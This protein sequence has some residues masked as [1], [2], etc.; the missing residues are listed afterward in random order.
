MKTCLFNHCRRM[1]VGAFSSGPIAALALLTVLALPS[2]A[3]EFPTK[4]IRIV[5]PS[6]PGIGTDLIARLIAQRLNERLGWT[7]LVD[8]KPGGNYLIGS[9]TVLQQPADGHTVL[10]AVSSMTVLPATV[11]DLPVNML[12]DFAAVTRVATLPTVVLVTPALPAKTMPELVAYAKKNPTALSYAV[13]GSGSFHHLA[14]EL[15]KQNLLISMTH[16]PYKDTTLIADVASG[17]V[18]VAV[19]SVASVAQQIRAGTLRGLAILGPNRSPA[20]PDVPTM[21]ELGLPEIDGEAWLGTLVRA[22]TPP[23]VIRILNREIV[24]AMQTPEFKD[25]LPSMGAG[26]VQDTPEAFARLYAADIARWQQVVQT[27]KLKF[28]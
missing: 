14:G 20:I 21:T 15:L 17:R 2:A 11:K 27:S 6:G 13:T 19:I 22:G 10:L 24:A 12:K 26:F 28:D 5:V 16:V 4:P 9:Q 25:K 23:D 3:Q 7:V 1:L 8:N 18:Q